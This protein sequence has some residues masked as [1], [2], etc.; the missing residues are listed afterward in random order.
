MGVLETRVGEMNVDNVF[1]RLRF[2][3]W[4]LMHN[5][6]SSDMGRIWVLFDPNIA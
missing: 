4:K 2:P 6:S 5:Y 1:A 3:N